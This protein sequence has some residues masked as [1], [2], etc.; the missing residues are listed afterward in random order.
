MKQSQFSV[1]GVVLAGGRGERMQGQDK[2]LVLYNGKPLIEYALSQLANTNHILINHNRSQQEYE[3]YGVE[4]IQDN[5]LEGIE[6][7][8][9]P[10][11]GIYTALKA[12]KDDWVLFVP[13]DT[14][15]LPK[16]FADRLLSPLKSYINSQDGSQKPRQGA[17]VFDGDF[18]Q[19]LHLVLHRSVA[20]NLLA[21][22]RT[23]QRRANA[24]LTSLNLIQVDFS[25]VKSQFKNINQIQDVI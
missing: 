17:V 4:L 21:F 15:E 22:L 8:S 14:P 1:T 10:L 23:G 24:W 20:D 25:D 16:Q 5:P 3:E 13:C 6:P 11:V 7:Q 12:A 2:G 18:L 19:P 9:G